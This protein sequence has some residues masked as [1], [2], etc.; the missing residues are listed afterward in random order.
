MDN[1]NFLKN[2]ITGKVGEERLKT[3]LRQRG[4]L[5]VETGQENWLPEEIHA[6]IRSNQDLMSLSVRHT[7][8]F[9]TYHPKFGLTYWDAKIKTND[10]YEDFTL[11]KNFYQA[12]RIRQYSGQKIVIAFLDSDGRWRANWIEELEVLDEVHLTKNPFVVIAKNSA[13]SLGIFLAVNVLFGEI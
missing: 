4:F 13:Y 8:D 6:Q 9:L 1:S 7:P 2:L 12:M 5:I 10:T 11:Q 3:Q